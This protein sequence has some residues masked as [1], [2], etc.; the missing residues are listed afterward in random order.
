MEHFFV[1]VS[2]AALRVSATIL[3][4][5]QGPCVGNQVLPRT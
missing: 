5:I 3:E 4:V 1:Y 2:G